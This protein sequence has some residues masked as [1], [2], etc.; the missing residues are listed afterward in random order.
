M[1]DELRTLTLG[2]ENAAVQVREQ[3]E[4]PQVQSMTAPVIDLVDE[5][6]STYT[7][8]TA[9]PKE[10]FFDRGGP[11]ILQAIRLF[12]Q[13]VNFARSEQNEPLLNILE[14][15]EVVEKQAVSLALPLQNLCRWT[16]L[17]RVGVRKL[18]RDLLG[19][20]SM[21]PMPPKGSIK[22][23]RPADN[24]GKTHYVVTHL[25]GER[26]LCRGYSLNFDR[27]GRWLLGGPD[28]NRWF[29]DLWL[30]PGLQTVDS[31]VSAKKRKLTPGR[32]SK[33]S[34]R[35]ERSINQICD[36]YR[37]KLGETRA[38]AR[39]QAKNFGAAHGARLD[40]ENKDIMSTALS[41]IR[42]L[43]AQVVVYREDA[44]LDDI[45]GRIGRSKAEVIDDP[46]IAER[47]AE[48]FEYHLE[49]RR[50]AYRHFRPCGSFAMPRGYMVFAD[51]GVPG[52][53]PQEEQTELTGVSGVAVGAGYLS[54]RYDVEA[55]KRNP[56]ALPEVE[57]L[58]PIVDVCGVSTLNGRL[59]EDMELV[60][61]D[62][63]GDEAPGDTD[64]MRYSLVGQQPVDMPLAEFL[65]KTSVRFVP[66]I[67]NFQRRRLFVEDL[68]G[69]QDGITWAMSFDDVNPRFLPCPK[70]KSGK[71]S[72]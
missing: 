68:Q 46:T 52:H 55:L 57:D 19:L 36:A 48:A 1:S 12:C 72:T 4:A 31:L 51:Q 18:Q 37:K 22:L 58:S 8:G 64:F 65:R 50:R 53:I 29:K 15:E 49:R 59:V 39:M 21:V 41:S 61:K 40:L 71:S 60:S 33:L 6:F 38:A 24:V 30:T 54:T 5:L 66:M 32:A 27:E 14:L 34:K 62:Q 7:T 3:A 26:F 23:N 45:V 16:V 20:V 35:D 25:F 43:L 47:E 56:S 28:G 63:A 10:T 70:K 44:V 17:V 69:D 13:K 2:G 9:W 11:E 42:A 67:V